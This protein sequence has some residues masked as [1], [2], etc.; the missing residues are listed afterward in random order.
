MEVSRALLLVTALFAGCRTAA[1][2]EEQPRG[3]S[4]PSETAARTT[5]ATVVSAASAAASFQA[6]PL[7]SSSALVASSSASASTSG[8]D[9]AAADAPPP[10]CPD[11]MVLVGRYCVDR[12]EDA[13][14]VVGADGSLTP[15]PYY[16][17]LV[18]G[19]KYVAVNA[20]GQFPQGY[21]S[22]VESKAAC[23]AAGKRLCSRAEWSRACRGKGWMTYPYGAR[24]EKNRCNSGKNH[25]LT[26]LFKIPKGKFKYDEH[27]NS[28]ELNKTPGFLAKSGEYEGCVSDLGL[29]D[30]VGNLHEWVSDTLD[31]AFI[32][33][34]KNEDV[35]RVDQPMKVGD[36]VFMGGFF[37]TTSQHGPGC[38]YTTVAHEPTYHDYSTGFR[39]CKSAVLP[40]PEKKPKQA[41]PPKGKGKTPPK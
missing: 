13:L 9:S 41:P 2:A 21:I 33:A 37:S 25:L 35:E 30:M 1:P 14:A 10:P 3:S 8:S 6:P 39:C 18:S 17:R 12:Y 20:E 15:H 24:V 40:K 32:E 27:F 4:S 11:D 16:E 29:H 28:P 7:P 34:F 36:G 19:E 31:D 22:R 26:E 38:A 23:E 5:A